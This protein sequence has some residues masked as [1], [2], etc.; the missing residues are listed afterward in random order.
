MYVF[1]SWV[2][3]ILNSRP[4]F[5]ALMKRLKQ[6]WDKLK[7]KWNLKNDWHG[8][9]IMGVFA[10]TGFSILYVKDPVF[11]F[12]GYYNLEP[13]VWKVLAY[14]AIIYPLY[15]LLLIGW[16]TILG[17]PKFFWWML[18]KMNGRF[19]KQFKRNK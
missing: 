14:I 2:S 15:Q 16:G 11:N 8:L 17:Q 13:G 5:A 9:W 12:F 1:Y 3:E 18:G 4:T 6:Y 19:L 10:V 7:E